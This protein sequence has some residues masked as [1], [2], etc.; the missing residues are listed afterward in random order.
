M[1]LPPY[2]RG[3]MTQSIMTHTDL[4]KNDSLFSCINKSELLRHS[5]GEN[6]RDFFFI[7]IPVFLTHLAFKWPIMTQFRI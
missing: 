3:I 7:K 6:I 5:P 2:M 4:D 1:T